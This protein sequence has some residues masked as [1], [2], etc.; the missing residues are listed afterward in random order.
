M[1]ASCYKNQVRLHRLT[2]NQGFWNLLRAGFVYVAA[3]KTAK[4]TLS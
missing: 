1:E 4:L 3:V 2:K